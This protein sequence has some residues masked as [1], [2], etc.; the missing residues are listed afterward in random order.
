[1][2]KYVEE[3]VLCCCF[4]GKVLNIIDYQHVDALIKIDK[5]VDLV[6][7]HRRCILVLKNPRRYIK[8]TAARIYLLR[9]YAYRLNQVRLAH[10]R[11]AEHK[12][13]VKRLATRIIG[14]S[15]TYAHGKLVAH[16]VAIVL[17]SI[18]RVQL[19]VDVAIIHLPE[20]IAHLLL[21]LFK[22]VLYYRTLLGAFYR[23]PGT[24]IL[25]Y[26]IEIKRDF[27]IRPEYTFKSPAHQ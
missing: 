24:R 26:Y 11:R 12:Q 7:P 17:E 27:E 22:A 15:L 2:V 10:A 8:H 9:A 3:G 5:L 6:I 19:R 1:M 16:A 21:R 25:V 14:N 20:R 23:H 13:R 4:P 18:F